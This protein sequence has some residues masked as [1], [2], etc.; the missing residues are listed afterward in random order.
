MPSIIVNDFYSMPIIREKIVGRNTLVYKCGRFY[1]LDYISNSFKFEEKILVITG[2]DLEYPEK[3]K[4]VKNGINV[5]ENIDNTGQD[6]SGY[7]SGISSLKKINN[8]EW[9]IFTNSSCPI[10]SLE[11]LIEK[12]RFL[13]KESVLIGPGF[14]SLSKSTSFPWIA[15]HIQTYCFA[16]LGKDLFF[17]KKFI[18]LQINNTFFQ[19]KRIFIRSLEIELSKEYIKKKRGLIFLCTNKNYNIKSNLY[20]YPLIIDSRFSLIDY[21]LSIKK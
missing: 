20:G 6:F 12:I 4:W 5:I 19:N 9:Y 15:P 18:E 7:L 14:S 11:L 17:L 16:I 21:I 3:K 8:Y 2:G 10:T 13:K 1:L